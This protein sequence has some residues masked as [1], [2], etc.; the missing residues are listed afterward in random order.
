M[1]N[2]HN[3]TVTRYRDNVLAIQSEIEAHCLTAGRSPSTVEIVAVTKYV[4]PEAVE[5]LLAAGVRH[6]GENRLQQ[7]L[8]KLMLP[9]SQ[10]G[11]WHFIGRL[12][13]NKVREVVK[14]FNWIH[15]IDSLELG[16]LI[17]QTAAACN[18][19]VS[20]LIQVNISGEETKSGV[21][22][23]DTAPLVQSLR[24]IPGLQIRGLMTMAPLTTDTAL[25]RSVFRELHALFQ[26]IRRQTAD[27]EWSELSMGMSDDFGIAIEEGATMVRI[28]R[29]LLG[30]T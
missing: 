18:R 19:T 10:G 22:P 21:D 29:R 23:Q 3:S 7:A 12:Q 1:D 27:P 24:D 15:S 13:K 20:G 30:D 6:F 17:G 16:L 25:I 5:P 11:V 9:A 8:P 4:G 2:D 28:G 14:R 26:D